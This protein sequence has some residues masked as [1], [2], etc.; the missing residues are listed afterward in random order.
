MR[1]KKVVSLYALNG[2][3]WNQIEQMQVFEINPLKLK[4][5]L[6][7]FLDE[8]Q[9][10][11]FRKIFFRL[12]YSI[13]PKK[14]ADRL[15][16]KNLSYE[17]LESYGVEDYNDEC[18]MSFDRTIWTLLYS[19]IRVIV[20]RIVAIILTVI[21]TPVVAFWAPIY[22]LSISARYI[23]RNTVRI[24]NKWFLSDKLVSVDR[25]L[26]NVFQKWED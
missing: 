4:K 25:R 19:V 10:N 22:F 18:I 14:A 11:I 16:N 17:Q 20:L 6:L 24:W 7:Y 3:Y 1:M 2:I 9:M 5:K 21:M 8:E 26:A 15:D 12:R 23:K 13:S